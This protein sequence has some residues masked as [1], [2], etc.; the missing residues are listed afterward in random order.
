MARKLG[1]FATIAAT[2][3][4]LLL[5]FLY[6]DQEV[7]IFP[8]GRVDAAGAP[9]PLM[10]LAGLQAPAE[11][12]SLRGDLGDSLTGIYATAMLPDGR[13][14]PNAATEPTV[15][16]FYGNGSSIASSENV[17]TG[18]RR[19][20]LNVLCVDYGGYGASTGACSEKSCYEA[21]SAAYTYLIEKRHVAPNL[22]V[23]MGRSLGTGVGI[24]LA[25]R[26]DCA[27]LITVSAYTTMAEMSVHQYP[28]VPSAVVNLMLRHRFDSADKIAGV[29]C[30]IL[31]VHCLDD[32]MIPCAMSRRLAHIA[33]APV[34]LIEPPT[35]RHNDVFNVG[36]AHLFDQLAAFAHAHAD[37]TSHQAAPKLPAGSKI[38]A[39][40]PGSSRTSLRG[41]SL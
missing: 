19:R 15:L 16:Y 32:P 6:V 30:P 33:T 36:G 12:V 21:A 8:A 14:D 3:Y 11:I 35:G 40:I 28:V 10:G 31:L 34:T 17:I 29:K 22:L 2:L 9:V 13:V 27:A 41:V 24:D 25:S 23:I 20:R 39:T 26:R 37:Q 38:S 4:V 7:L 5:L 18:L 1:R